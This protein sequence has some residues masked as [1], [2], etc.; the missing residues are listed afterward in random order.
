M[1]VD[2]SCFLSVLRAAEKLPQGNEKVK[3]NNLHKGLAFCF[4][5][6]KILNINTA[7]P[8]EN[9]MSNY[10]ARVAQ[11][12]NGDFYAFIVNIDKG[13]YE[14]VLH[15]YKGRHFATM[16]AAEKSTAKHIATINK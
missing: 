13:G 12:A 15:S 9:D 7:T 1:L 6:C 5:L 2:S 14:R 8:Q 11:T 16:K 4:L 10:Q 3:E